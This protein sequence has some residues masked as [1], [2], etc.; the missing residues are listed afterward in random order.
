M[1]GSNDKLFLLIPLDLVGKDREEV[2]VIVNNYILE[3]R[4][5]LPTV[6]ETEKIEMMKAAELVFKITE[7]LPCHTSDQER[8]DNFLNV[9]TMFK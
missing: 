5:E 1:T 3:N 7:D 2:D 8:I 4:K 6:T 9:F